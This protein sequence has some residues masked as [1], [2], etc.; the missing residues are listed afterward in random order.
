MLGF[1]AT[2]VIVD[3]SDGD[4]SCYSILIGAGLDIENDEGKCSSLTYC[5]GCFDRLDLKDTE[6]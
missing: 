2:G 1:F 4:G 3:A 6:G 5:C